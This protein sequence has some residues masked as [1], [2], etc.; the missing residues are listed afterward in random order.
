MDISSIC[1][2]HFNLSYLIKQCSGFPQ[3]TELPI[4]QIIDSHN[5]ATEKDPREDK[6]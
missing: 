5:Y 4:S 3:Y 2:S 1:K 6:T